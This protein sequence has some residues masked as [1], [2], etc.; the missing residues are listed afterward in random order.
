MLITD[1]QKSLSMGLCGL[2]PLLHIMVKPLVALSRG[3]EVS[4]RD[5]VC[6]TKEA[7]FDLT[8]TTASSAPQRFCAIIDSNVFSRNV[9][10]ICKMSCF[11]ALMAISAV[12]QVLMRKL[13]LRAGYWD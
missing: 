13:G 1:T 8:F 6:S 2:S 10:S 7:G 9:T 4:G 3:C 11:K 12:R 5:C